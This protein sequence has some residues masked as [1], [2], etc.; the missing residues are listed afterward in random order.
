MLAQKKKV[1]H[2]QTKISSSSEIQHEKAHSDEEVKFVEKQACKRTRIC[3]AQGLQGLQGSQGSQ[4]KM[5][6]IPTDQPADKNDQV[7]QGRQISTN[8]E[9]RK[10]IQNKQAKII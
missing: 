6:L 10:F 9:N 3:I 8:K 5:S 1:T 4:D 2:L 7:E